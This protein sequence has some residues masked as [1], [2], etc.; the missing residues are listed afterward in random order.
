M[1]SMK[2]FTAMQFCLIKIF[3]KGTGEQKKETGNIMSY[4]WNS[5]ANIPYLGVLPCGIT[6]F[7][8]DTQVFTIDQDLFAATNPFLLLNPIA[9]A[10]LN[11]NSAPSSI[12]PQVNMPS[13]QQ[14]QAEAGRIASGIVNNINAGLLNQ[15]LAQS[16]S[17]I[18]MQKTKLNSLLS[19]SELSEENKTEATRLLDELQNLENKLAELSKN[20]SSMDS[21]EALAQ[22]QEIEKNIRE[23]ILATGKIKTGEPVKNE[24]KVENSEPVKENPNDE[25]VE[26]QGTGKNSEKVEH[27]ITEEH[28]QLADAFHDAINGPGTGDDFDKVCEALTSDNVVEVMAAYKA[29]YGTSFMDDF[30]DDADSGFCC[31][32]GQKVKYG[33]HIAR[34]LRARA[35][36]AGIYDDCK[37]DFQA[38]NEEMDSFWAVD[39]DVYKNYD[40]I[41]EKIAQKENIS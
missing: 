9:Q 34:E 6:N 40:N 2:M 17:N 4:T 38:I 12:F 24:E 28:R 21:S 18:A 16:T 31:A 8:G 1:Y 10:M 3:Y 19:D 27:K 32:G 36:E 33:K 41:V 13:Q 30:M 22:A 23:I 29:E 26:K 25:K 14:I 5:Y 11:R 20:V 15:S 35:I 39:N 7:G 37:K